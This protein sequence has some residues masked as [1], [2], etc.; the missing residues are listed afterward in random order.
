MACLTR[1]R[2]RGAPAGGILQGMAT[3]IVTRLRQRLSAWAIRLVQRFGP[4]Q[5]RVLG[6][7]FRV[8]RHVFN[9]RFYLTSKFM[10]RHLRLR[11]SDSVLDM[12]TGSGIQAIVAAAT[13]ARV[14][15]IDIN[16]EAVRLARENARANGVADRVTVL[17]GDL[18][19]PLG[20]ASGPAAREFVVRPSGRIRAVAAPSADVR[21]EARTT[22]E[23]RF[24]LILLNP[25]YL[26]GPVRSPLDHAMFDPGR[27]LHR[28]FFAEARA[29]LAP[30]G[31]VLMVCS[32]LAEPRRALAIAGELGWEATL[33][34]R[35]RAWG[36][37]LFLYQLTPRDPA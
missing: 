35:K 31:C 14:V 37:T 21:A 17:E 19:A 5:V 15:A 2:L 26:E 3:S 36:E 1:A 30:A 22:N 10:A 33:L 8:N 25:P 28:R 13:A 9:P 7:T 4:H 12:G 20:G 23:E 6:R 24:D 29:F 11:P 32:S 18:F 34:H 27:R 16:P